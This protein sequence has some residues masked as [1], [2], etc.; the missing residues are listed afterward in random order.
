MQTLI[1]VALLS[2]LRCDA[3]Y[4]EYGC[5]VLQQEHKLKSLQERQTAREPSNRSALSPFPHLEHV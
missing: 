2:R 5:N 4:A 1:S 3:G